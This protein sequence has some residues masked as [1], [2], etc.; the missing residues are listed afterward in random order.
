MDEKKI[1]NYFCG[2]CG[3][4]HNTIQ[5][6]NACETKCIKEKEQEEAALKRQM[7][8]KEKQK[9]KDEIDIKCQEIEDLIHNYVKDYGAI[10]LSNSFS[11]TCFPYM[12]KFLRSWWF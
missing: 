1:S 8:D 3:K 2:I 5:E 4:P 9:R 12:S 7:L 6:R 11:D 10:N